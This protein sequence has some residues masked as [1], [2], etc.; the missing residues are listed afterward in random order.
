MS[1]CVEH[2][3]P[4]SSMPLK[5]SFPYHP[6]SYLV[7]R[8]HEHFYIDGAWCAPSGT[9]TIDVRSAATEEVIG[10]IPTATVDDVG[11]AVAAARRA[12]DE[13]WALTTA[14]ERA[15]WLKKLASALEARVQD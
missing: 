14:A 11:Q 7:P 9:A 1:G 8:N 15:D 2:I 6:S 10:R 5:V 12:F 4:N 3:R 13:G